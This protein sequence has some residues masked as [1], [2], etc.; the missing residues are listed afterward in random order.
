MAQYKVEFLPAD[1]VIKAG[2]THKAA[3]TIEGVINRYASQGYEFVQVAQISI[4]EEPG[5][6]GG[7]FGAK[8]TFMNYN[9][10]VFRK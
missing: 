8:T 5:C 10:L 2:K 6:L 3:D 7:I 4:K 9:A 1:M